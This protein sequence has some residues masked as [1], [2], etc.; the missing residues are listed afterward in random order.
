MVHDSR[1]AAVVQANHKDIHLLLAH[2]QHCRQL[3]KEA[4]FL[5]AEEEYCQRTNLLLCTN[6]RLTLFAKQRIEGCHGNE[7]KVNFSL[8]GG[9]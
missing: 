2:L 4:H 8:R 5:G 3:I 6:L 1:F 7:T 9:A